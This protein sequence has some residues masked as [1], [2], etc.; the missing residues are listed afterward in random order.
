MDN[1]R[2][3][4]FFNVYVCRAVNSLLLKSFLVA[5][6]QTTKKCSFFRPFAWHICCNYLILFRVEIPARICWLLLNV[7]WRSHYLR[8]FVGQFIACRTVC[9]YNFVQFFRPLFAC[10][11]CRWFFFILCFVNLIKFLHFI[12]SHSIAPIQQ[13]STR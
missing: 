13:T 3:S 1:N 8:L 4:V 9:L 12:L 6:Y 11:I 2:V 5:F 7:C 10:Y